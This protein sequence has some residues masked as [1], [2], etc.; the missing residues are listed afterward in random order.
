MKINSIIAS[1]LV[2]LSTILSA[3]ITI[4]NG[5]QLLGA[6]QDIN[7][8]V[9][10]NTCIDYI[11]KY[12]TADINNIEWQTYIANGV[13]YNHNM[14][15]IDSLTKGNGY[16]VKGN[17]DCNITIAEPVADRYSRSVQEVV[18]DHVTVFNGKMISVYLL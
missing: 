4:K 18:M 10:D 17:A 16:W 1:S 6:T 14:S 15:P 7:V 8:S 5:W 12:D 11:W 2:L 9:F 13:E 3:D